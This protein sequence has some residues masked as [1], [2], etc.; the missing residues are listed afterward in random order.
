MTENVKTG[1]PGL[2]IAARDVKSD[3][4]VRV[5]TGVVERADEDT[6]YVKNRLH[7]ITGI[8]VLDLNG[9]MV[10]ERGS[11]LNGKAAAILYRNGQLVSVK[12]FPFDQE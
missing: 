4:E 1:Q 8:P 2:T 7:N 5:I 6:I 11:T 12:I 9:E 3:I 10:M